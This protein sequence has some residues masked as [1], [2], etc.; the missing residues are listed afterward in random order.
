MPILQPS[1]LFSLPI[2]AF[3]HQMHSDY[4][5]NLDGSLQRTKLLQTY[6]LKHQM[7]TSRPK[8]QKTQTTLYLPKTEFCKPP[9]HIITNPEIK[10]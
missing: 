9:K 8:K 1:N 10:P 2:E 5:L 7:K 4:A 3:K 6:L